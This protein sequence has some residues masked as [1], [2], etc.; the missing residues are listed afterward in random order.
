MKKVFSENI[1]V[2]FIFLSLV[3]FLS[4]LPFLSAGFG[5]E[6][7]SW[8]LP[9]TAKNIAVSGQYELSRAP[10][11]PIQEI[12][13]S[14]MW[15]AGPFA[16]NLL[17]AVASVIA[18]LFFALSLRQLEFKHYLFASFAFAFTP[19]VFI[20]S[21]YT[22]DY[23][24]AMAF[25]MGS[26]YFLLAWLK[27][28]SSAIF[29][30]RQLI[31]SGILLG[32]SIGFRITSG[33][34]LIPFCILLFNRA[35]GG[36]RTIL[37]FSST[38]AAIGLLTFIPVINT[39]G[40]S[41]FTFSDQ[42]PYPN[43]PKVFYKATFGVF[44]TIGIAALIFYK[45][46]FLLGK[47]SMKE[48][49]FA[50]EMP[51]KLLIACLA[52]IAIY[53]IS[54]LRLPQKSAYFIPAIPFI[55]LMCGYFLSS[56]SFKILCV[57][58]V[59]SSFLFSINLTD[60]LRGSAHSALSVKFKLAGQEI[61]LD[62]LTGPVFSDYTKR[63]NKIA[64]TEKVFEK[65]RSEQRKSV[66]ICGWWYNEL[67]VR[68]W[69]SEKNH[70]VVLVFYADKSTIE[71]YISENYEIYYLP[72]QNIYNDQYSQMSYTDSVAKSYM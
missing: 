54:Y 49:L 46:K 30:W 70:N 45:I 14:L 32:L 36:S 33:A 26:F 5:A 69:N 51:F 29:A 43:L 22:I 18:V 57:L 41:F 64:F 68:N 58:M 34:M 47:L 2:Q 52:T 1:T 16:Y 35:K 39:Y 11:H 4:R 19:I 56:R 72:E 59:I 8:L 71:K 63:L 6:E 38:T 31:L 12:I 24:P 40:L 62:P 28:S 37:V 61:F 50:S 15:N 27:N 60:S 10:G 20:S 13:Y 21:T 53:V 66:L 44:G 3:V 48:N 42:F 9:I 67:Q 65:V 17:T 7:D 55:I 25:V 23:M